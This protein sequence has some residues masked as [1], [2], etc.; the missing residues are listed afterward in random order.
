MKIVVAIEGVDGSGKSSL[1]SF[2]QRLCQEHGQSCSLIG[3]R[4]GYITPAI[5]KL[6]Q[7]LRE[8]VRALTPQADLFLRIAREYQRAHVAA[9]APQGIVLLD[10]FVLTVLSLARVYGHDADPLTPFLREIV[11]RA[12]L[13]ATLFVHCPF[14]VAYHRV[15]NRR[16]DSS[17]RH[18]GEAM[19]RRV[20]D[21][22]ADDFQ[23]GLFTG[24]Q[25]PVDNSKSLAEGQ[26]QVA[27][28]LLPYFENVREAAKESP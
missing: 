23:R 13:R 28:Y 9:L 18:R 11:A 24:Q 8:E 12:D 19:L 7:V 2:I 15:K 22:M 5:A 25:W 27:S 6:S 21:F 1:A 20:A 16:P 3:R 26:E 4:A 10:R 17:T 14:E